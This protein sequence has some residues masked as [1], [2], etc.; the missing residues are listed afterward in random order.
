MSHKVEEN[1]F[2]LKVSKSQNSIAQKTNEIFD[3]FLPWLHRAE[4]LSNFVF[5]AMKFQEFFFLRF[6]DL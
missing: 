4:L 3:K 6:N 2:A 1:T 5:W